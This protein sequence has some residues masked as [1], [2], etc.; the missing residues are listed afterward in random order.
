MPARDSSDDRP[1]RNWFH[2]NKG[3]KRFPGW[4]RMT[5]SHR[6]IFYVLLDIANELWFPD[7]IQIYEAELADE[8]GTSTRSVKRALEMLRD[9][10]VLHF[11]TVEQDKDRRVA[12]RIRI[13]YAALTACGKRHSAVS[14]AAESAECRVDV[15]ETQSECGSVPT[16]VQLRKQHPDCPVGQLRVPE[17]G[18]GLREGD[19]CP[20]C[21]THPLSIRFKTDAGSRTKQRF[22]ACSGYASGQCRGFTWNLGSTPY[23]PSQRVLSQ[24]LVGARDVP[25][26]PPLVRDLLASPRSETAS[27]TVGTRR[28]VD[29]SEW[30]SRSKFLPVDL[31][32]ESLSELAPDLAESHRRAGSPKRAVL[33]DVKARLGGTPRNVDGERL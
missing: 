21:G 16:Q 1:A 17:V 15:E 20:K 18:G 22:L 7:S 2:L 11:G 33:R 29:L 8:S 14:T 13:D 23:Q 6:V 27:E 19:L 24:A 28:P 31:M 25:G 10:G 26:R 30:V 32:L 4:K 3:W 12:V 9:A 5:S